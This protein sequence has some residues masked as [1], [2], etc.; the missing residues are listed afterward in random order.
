VER[1]PGRRAD[2][3]GGLELLVYFAR[4][5]ASFSGGAA[6]TPQLPMELARWATWHWAR[7][8]ASGGAFIASLL[9]LVRIG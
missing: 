7:T 5:N 2:G 6:S 3:R 1:G 4:A 9:S 8:V